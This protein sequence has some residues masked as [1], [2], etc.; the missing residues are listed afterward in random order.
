MDLS[1]YQSQL[2][3]KKSQLVSAMVNYKLA[4]LDLKIQSL[5][6]FEKD[7]TVLK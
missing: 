1:L 2:S 6:D 4:L 5:W 3:Q 7:E